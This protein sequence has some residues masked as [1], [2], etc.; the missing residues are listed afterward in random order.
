MILSRLVL[1]R[2]LVVF[3]S[4]G[5]QVWRFRDVMDYARA[6]FLF[7]HRQA[8][9]SFSINPSAARQFSFRNPWRIS[10]ERNTQTSNEHALSQSHWLFFWRNQINAITSVHTSIRI[11]RDGPCV[12]LLLLFAQPNNARRV[13]KFIEEGE[14]TSFRSDLKR[15]ENNSI[16]HFSAVNVLNRHQD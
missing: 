3:R 2:S 10:T 4:W 8:R 6:G 7:C 16:F 13:G 12:Y 5:S 14:S 11:K 1:Y 15:D 9:K